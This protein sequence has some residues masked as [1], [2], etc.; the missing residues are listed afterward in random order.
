MSSKKIK[1]ECQGAGHTTKIY[2]GGKDLI[3]A[4]PGI[5]GVELSIFV[6]D[7]VKLKLYERAHPV[8]FRGKAKIIEIFGEENYCLVDPQYIE[9]LKKETEEVR[10]E[11]NKAFQETDGLLR[12]NDGL[13]KEIS[14]LKAKLEKK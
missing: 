9:G 5:Y 14:A 4:V 8:V 1:I 7:I 6:D 10:K 13:K 12:K 11:R 2:V 3:K